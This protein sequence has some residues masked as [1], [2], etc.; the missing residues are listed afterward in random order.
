MPLRAISYNCYGIKSTIPD[1]QELCSRCDIL[2]LQETWLHRDELQILANVH[3]DFDWYGKSS[4]NSE[5]GIHVGRPYGGTGI[6]WRKSISQSVKVKNYGDP[7]IIGVTVSTDNGLL[8]FINVYL[9]YQCDDNYDEYMLCLGKI[10][11]IID[12]SASNKVGVIGDFNAALNTP[13]YRELADF[14][15]KNNLSISDQIMLG[16]NQ[17]NYTYVSDAHLTCSWLDHIITTADMHK[18]VTQ[19][20]IL[21]KRPASDHLPLAF[22]LEASM[23]SLTLNKGYTPCEDKAKT[24]NWQEADD[25]HIEKYCALTKQQL[26][27]IKPPFDALS[28]TNVGCNSAHHREA[29]DS[30]Y[31]KVC[32]IL[33][34]ASVDCIG[35]KRPQS[36]KGHIVP[37]WNDLVKDSHTQARE[38]YILWRNMGKPR[39]GQVCEL[40]RRTRLCFKYTL[41]QCKR[42]E[43]TLRADAMAKDFENKDTKA[44]WSKVAKM[45]NSK[46]PLASCVDGCHGEQD[47]AQMWKS[48]FEKIMNCVDSEHH[49]PFVMDCVYNLDSADHTVIEPD[50]VKDALKKAK[51]GKASGPD[52]LSMEHFI[53]ADGSISVYLSLLFTCMLTH[54]HMPAN[55]MK[56][57]IVPLIKNKN[58]D[59]SDKSNYRPIALVTPCSKLFEL[60]LLD[61]IEDN[62]YST[63]NQFGFKKKHATDMCLFTLKNV[64]E[65]YRKW[66]SPVYVCFLDASK[67]FD[68]INHWT[69]FRKMKDRGISALIIRILL[70]WYREQ[71]LTV[72]WG[73]TVSDCFHVTNGVRQ[74]SVLSPKCFAVYVDDLS[75]QL[76]ESNVGCTI[77]GICC[78]HLYYADDL[79]LLAPSAIALQIL[80]DLC[81]EYG[82]K[83]DIVYNP[84]KSICMVFKP[85]RFSLKCPPVY[86]GQTVLAYKS[87]AKYLGVWLSDDCTDN[88]EIKKQRQTLYA[89][90][91]SVLRKFSAC[92]MSV[93][94]SLFQSFCTNFYCCAMWSSYSMQTYSKIKVA[95]NN[96]CRYLLG[97]RK[98]CSA[99]HM[100]VTNNLHSL[101]TILR[102]NIYAFMHRI[103]GTPNSL[104]QVIQHN[105][106][107]RSG[108]MYERWFSALYKHN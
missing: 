1:L 80:L 93:K 78:N 47:I 20:T 30:Y 36:T 44:F 9:P 106:S 50:H 45:N 6:L 17:N 10:S 37:G 76:R 90:A 82:L 68:R 70:F 23:C 57:T 53:H 48:H 12:E 96:A 72:K 79:C 63:D 99:S 83:H 60:V 85:P 71:T 49:K 26:L 14:C 88:I 24:V 89:R 25:V 66:G 64:I 86:L 59:S 8:D 107:I 29:I 84:L 56:S 69:L 11:A 74:G 19:V 35:A 104:V 32:N 33:L 105:G 91:N 103:E 5:K 98:Q 100:L 42:Q 87:E 40:M 81:N 55:F 38:A 54:G 108:A 7:R 15:V 16:A 46:V 101:D 27:S 77:D 67:A 21:D 22:T 92:S 52:G 61:F 102:K 43:E 75:V 4:M 28:C 58:G 3:P 62:L 34:R 18:L 39:H 97:Y 73:Q 65:Y 31:D 13:F 51:R 94:I 2:F 95:Y 41:R